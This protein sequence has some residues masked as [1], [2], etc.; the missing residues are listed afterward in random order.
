MDK[1]RYTRQIGLKEIGLAGQEKIRKARVL[2]VGVGGLGAPISL[3]LT[4]AGIGRLGI[5]DD[6]VVSESNLHRQVLYTE[7]ELGQSKAV[8][9]AKR[10]SALNSDVQVKA[11][12]TRFTEENAEEILKDYDLVVDGCDNYATRYVIDDAARKL[13]KPYVYGAV[14][15]FEGQVS[16]FGVGADALHYRDLYPVAPPAPTDKSLVG[17]TPAIVGATMAHEVLKLVC[18]YG[19]L[20]AHRL[21]TINLLTMDTLTLDF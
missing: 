17:M 16:V 6:D 18:G 5:V 14:C 1:E 15:G 3:Y 11:Y 20:L 2:L 4:G 13:G 10:L 7:E 12:N 19:Q 21:W 8:C 9:A